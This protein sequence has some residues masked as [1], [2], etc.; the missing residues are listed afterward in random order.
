MSP[1]RGSSALLVAAFTVVAILLAAAQFALLRDT[2]PPPDAITYFDVAD[3]IARVGYGPALPLHWAPLYPLWL[4]AARAVSSP[5]VEDE[6]AVSA[7]ADAVALIV[8]CVVVALAFRSLARLCWPGSAATRRA[9]VAYAAGCAVFFAFA[10]LRVGLRMPDALVTT[11]VVVALWAW[12]QAMARRLDPRWT[13]LAGLVSGVA[14]LARA[15]LLHW[16]LV[17][18]ALACGLAPAADRRRRAVA[19][20]AAL[21]GLLLVFAPHTYL[22]S[23]A[24]GYLTWG[25]SG[26]IALRSAM[27][28]SGPRMVPRGPPASPAATSAC[29]P[30]PTPSAFRASTTRAASSTM[31]E[32]CSGWAASDARW[33]APPAGVWSATTRRRLR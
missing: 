20:G 27:A 18:A 3:E 30:T 5:R 1:W 12:S 11:L 33:R 15:N 22:L 9:W 19:F 32:C 29:S 31:R 14:F 21:L 17:V 8:L 28:P 10:V 4:L 2:M 26:K 24:R 13:A 7:A 25:E 6:L 16:S 23:S